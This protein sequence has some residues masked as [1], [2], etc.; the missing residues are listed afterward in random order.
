MT[1]NTVQTIT[2]YVDSISLTRYDGG[3]HHNG[4]FNFRT[5]KT[6]N[7]IQTAIDDSTT[8]DGDT[9]WLGN[10]NYTE[11][12]NINKKITIRPISGVGVVIQPL[13]PNLPI[14]TINT[15]GSSTTIRDIVIDGSTGNA[16]IYVNNSTTNEI[17]G[18]NIINNLN[19]IYL[20]NSTENVISGNIILNNSLNG[21][22]ISTGSDN[23]VSSNIITYNSVAGINVQNSNKCRIYSNL[24]HNNYDGIHLNNSTAEIHLNSI[25]KNSRYGLYNTGNG[26]VNATNNW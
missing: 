24:I 17:L 11:N 3:I 12:I 21:M 8:I 16:G 4:T 20:Y 23:E 5:Q 25:V 7:S 18:N 15:S 9:I 2:F 19:G 14:F 1:S 22:L 26:T 13:N 10:L 6:F